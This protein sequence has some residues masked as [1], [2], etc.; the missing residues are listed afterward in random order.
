MELNHFNLIVPV[1][2]T[3]THRL[4]GGPI[5]QQ[6]VPDDYFIAAVVLKAFQDLNGRDLEFVLKAYLPIRIIQI[7]DANRVSFVE[8]LGLVSSE[9]TPL[10]D[11]RLDELLDFL[12]DINTEEDVLNAIALFQETL[13]LLDEKRQVSIAGLISK[14]HD[15]SPHE[16]LE[17]PTIDNVEPY[18]FILSTGSEFPDMTTLGSLLNSTLRYLHIADETYSRA[19]RVLTNITQQ[20]IASLENEVK[21]Q[22]DRL[23]LRISHLEQ[24][25]ANLE[26]RYTQE[27]TKESA[28]TL[29]ARKTALKRDEER[30]SSFIAKSLRLRE[31]FDEQL[32]ILDEKMEWSRKVIRE[33]KIQGDSISTPCV[34]VDLSSKG[35][36]LLVPFILVGFTRRGKLEVEITPPSH[37]TF[38][39]ERVSRR[40]DFVNPF[41]ESSILLSGLKERVSERMSTD[42]ALRKHVRLESETL[43]LLS[44]KIGRQ[45]IR[46]GGNGL[47]ADG[48]AKL[49]LYESLKSVLYGIPEI[50]LPDSMKAQ[51]IGPDDT[52]CNVRFHLMDEEGQPIDEANIVFGSQRFQ[53]LSTGIVKASLLPGRYSGTVSAFGFLDSSIEFT[54]DTVQ[55]AVIPITLKPMPSEERLELVLDRLVKRA[56]RI[57]SVRSR[58]WNAFQKHGPTL[59]SIPAYRSALKELL[60]ELGYDPENWISQAKTRKGM[61]KRLL[62]RDD[63][64]DG[65][66]RDILRIAEDSK[67]SGGIMLLSDLLVELDEQGWDTVPD[68]IDTI[69][70]DMKRDGLI[71]G[72]TSTLS[73]ARIA[74][75]IPVALTDDPHQILEI[76]A[77]HE[78]GLTI[79][80]AVLTLGWTEERVMNTLELLIQRG[81]A[82]L[83]KSFSGGTKYWFPGL[84]GGKK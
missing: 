15:S 23:E 69:L 11:S 39:D 37:L 59:L 46:E 21:S 42:V 9:L 77:D 48:F 73:G 18:S 34:S 60:I 10:Q 26:I 25:V 36:I 82:K 20:Q 2:T 71:E 45:I 81:V 83:Q 12:E 16:L 30:R 22:L 4:E 63:R 53:S 68:E 38:T 5:V 74:Q 61:V 35:N 57:D 67:Q 19:R 41:T 66:R 33:L 52:M 65:I 84:R 31:K 79:E 1:M 8:H 62:K 29:K 40:K 64:T 72:I 50:D 55:D 13:D 44:L 14:N 78:G 80:E 76:A 49:D 28:S 54:I 58:L 7:R 51:V 43:N 75:F 27:K 24:E 6:A 47:V 17:W 70:D 56:G 32:A 3:G